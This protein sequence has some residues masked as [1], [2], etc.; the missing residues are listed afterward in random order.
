M[1][2]FVAGRGGRPAGAGSGRADGSRASGHLRQ[3]PVAASPASGEARSSLPGG[4]AIRGGW[5]CGS[6]ARL[7]VAIAVRGAA[8]GRLRTVAVAANVTGAVPVRFTRRSADVLIRRRGRGVGGVLA[9]Q[10]RRHSV[11]AAVEI[12]V[13]R[14]SVIQRDRT[15]V[16]RTTDD[17]EHPAEVRHQLHPTPSAAILI[18]ALEA[19]PPISFRQAGSFV[20][21][22]TV[23][24]CS[25]A[26]DLL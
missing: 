7:A 22:E 11:R 15:R 13:A 10:D 12:W 4:G 17:G 20:C 25:D 14:T 5:G 24:E 2:C 21:Q 6:C 26:Q 23:R 16:R 18:D 19:S 9:S 1:R 3:A 8:V